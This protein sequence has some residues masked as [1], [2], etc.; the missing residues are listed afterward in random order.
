[1][2]LTLSGKEFTLRCDMRALANAKREAGIDIGKLNDDVV[3]VGTLVYFM[4]QSGAKHA[5]VPFKYELDDFLGLIEVRDLETLTEAMN[6]LFGV[7]EGKK[8]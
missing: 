5:D 8:K 1:M 2:K 4:A 6:E 7:G 3:E